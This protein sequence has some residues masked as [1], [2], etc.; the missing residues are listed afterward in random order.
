M[1]GKNKYPMCQFKDIDYE[2]EMSHSIQRYKAWEEHKPL[3]RIAAVDWTPSFLAV[4][5][6]R[7]NDLD[8]D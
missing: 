5:E 8:G 3:K 1:F 7:Y 2:L 6:H 4:T